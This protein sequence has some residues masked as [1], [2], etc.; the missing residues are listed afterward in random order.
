MPEAT[1]GAQ[2]DLEFSATGDCLIGFGSVA[3]LEAITNP[4]LSQ[5]VLRWPSTGLELLPELSD[6]NSQV[7]RLL[8]TVVA[9]D[10]QKQSTMRND[11][12]GMLCEVHEKIEFFGCEMYS[13]TLHLDISR[14]QINMEIANRNRL[15]CR[16]L[17]NSCPPR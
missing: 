6:K 16:L 4:R 7:L 12:V 17:F 2:T 14:L 1:Y 9:P 3:W 13:S 8:H 5:N 11:F 10:G 15:N